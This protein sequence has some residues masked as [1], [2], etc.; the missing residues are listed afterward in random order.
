M[1]SAVAVRHW[2][3]AVHHRTHAEV[4]GR[5]RAFIAAPHRAAQPRL[6]QPLIPATRPPAVKA[7]DAVSAGIVVSAASAT[8]LVAPVAVLAG[9]TDAQVSLSASAA[10]GGSGTYAYQWYRGTSAGFVPSAA[11]L[12]AQAT[13]LALRDPAATGGAAGLLPD[14]PYFYVL[15]ASDGQA[16]VYSN[17]VIGG[18]AVPTTPIAV[19]PQSGPVLLAYIGSSTWA[20]NQGSGQVPSLID[21]DLHAAWPAANEATFNGAVSGTTTA[22]FLP[23]QPLNNAVKAAVQNFAGYKVLRLMI[24]S[25]DAATGQPLATWLS[26]MQAIIQD[27][28]S[29]PVD[30]IVLEEIGLRLDGGNATVELIRQ[31]NAA[32]ASLLQA[33]VVLGTAN[34]FE[35]QAL[36]LATL[37]GDRIH[38]T[39]AGQA[40]LAANQTAELAGLFTPPTTFNLSS[41]GATCHVSM[42]PTQT[43]VLVSLGDGRPAWAYPASALPALTFNVTGKNDAVYFDWVPTSAVTVTGA[44]DAGVR[45]FVANT[46]PS[47]VA[48]NDTLITGGAGGITCQG[49]SE[50]HLVQGAFSC[51][52]SFAQLSLLDVGG[53]VVLYWV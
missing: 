18:L 51:S 14:V 31:Y 25:N 5:V 52:G 44:S 21:G 41:D 37:S 1:L 17:Q 19:D 49:V 30:V 48:I 10:V 29:W 26:N 11:T 32:R 7:P 23:G 40:D 43:R 50:L 16:T 35:N 47:Q 33:H 12:L 15:A 27:A 46:S 39:D 4:A 34:T 6:L 28:F 22:S 3:G 8:P 2:D 45:L 38:Q 13:A 20:I 53:G 24:G 36:H 9:A 42:D